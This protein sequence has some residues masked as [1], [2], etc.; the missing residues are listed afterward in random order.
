[1]KHDH[2]TFNSVSAMGQHCAGLTLEARQRISNDSR[3]TS[4]SD[5][6]PEWF[7]HLEYAEAT[8]KAATGGAWPEGAARMQALEASAPQCSDGTRGSMVAA[9]VGSRPSVPRYLASN[10]RAMSKMKRQPVKNKVVKLG[11]DIGGVCKF[12]AELFHNRGAAVLSY[13]KALE[14]SGYSVE[15]WALSCTVDDE[16]RPQNIATTS[17]L[18]KPANSRMC[19][20][21]IAFCFAHPAYFRRLIFAT[22]ET[23]PTTARELAE[24]MGCYASA[25]GRRYVGDFDAVLP[26]LSMCYRDN[27]EHLAAAMSFVPKCLNAQLAG[28]ADKPWQ[29]ERAA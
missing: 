15:L 17:V 4:D 13:V 14:L 16:Q 27:F 6:R 20:A 25:K 7:G 11:V 28:T 21:D 19:A 8:Q 24:G 9:V 2:L 12:D 18:V 5:R 22:V 10:P 26:P 3:P 29:L 1:M 23:A